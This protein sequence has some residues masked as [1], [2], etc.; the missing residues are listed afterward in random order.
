[1]DNVAAINRYKKRKNVKTPKEVKDAAKP[2]KGGVR[3]RPKIQSK[4]SGDQIGI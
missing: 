2:Y 4:Y 1:M 3:S